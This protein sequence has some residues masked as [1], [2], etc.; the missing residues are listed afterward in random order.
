MPLTAA[1]SNRNQN[2]DIDLERGLSKKGTYNFVDQV[3]AAGLRILPPTDSTSNQN[4][5]GHIDLERGLSKKSTYNFVDQVIAAGLSIHKLPS[6]QREEFLKYLA[7][8]V[9]N[10]SSLMAGEVNALSKLL[11]DHDIP[12]RTNEIKYTFAAIDFIPYALM[13][14]QYSEVFM[15]YGIIAVSL[16]SLDSKGQG[17]KQNCQYH[18]TLHTIAANLSS[19]SFSTRYQE[20]K[21]Y[22]SKL[23]IT[24]VS[25][26]YLKNALERSNKL[27]DHVFT[28]K[29]L[30]QFN[31]VV[32]LD[33]SES[34][35]QP[36]IECLNKCQVNITD[37]LE[38]SEIS[39]YTSLL[40]HPR[41]QSVLFNPFYKTQLQKSI[42]A[43]KVSSNN[44]L[45]EKIY[46]MPTLKYTRQ[47]LKD[48]S[49]D[50]TLND[51]TVKLII[52]NAYFISQISKLQQTT[53]VARAA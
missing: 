25:L 43:L 41:I 6:E 20:I 22:A 21:D 11:D 23:S 9:D 45:V 46:T 34:I 26:L 39:I 36:F 30:N 13:R 50:G 42:K 14:P 52:N 33:I 2:D 18:D 29:A 15:S 27:K 24:D 35:S 28:I 38:K 5:N 49:P 12:L 40:Q 47:T 8:K 1:T 10:K 37:M 19:R 7:Y 51:K 4:Q 48:I 44:P 17:V 32:A 3:I 16:A 53:D 31:S